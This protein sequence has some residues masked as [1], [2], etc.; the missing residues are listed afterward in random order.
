MKCLPVIKRSGHNM[1]FAII[2]GLVA[3]LAAV[4]LVIFLLYLVA[5]FQ[6]NRSWW[7]RGI[8]LLLP[9]MFSIGPQVTLLLRE[10]DWK[11]KLGAVLLYFTC[12][13]PTFYMC[14]IVVG[15]TGGLIAL[16]FDKFSR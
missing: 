3:Q 14:C 8:W 4:V 7:D 10:G 2:A 9:A 16:A 15:V 1:Q 13:I 6:N 11:Q 12:S 5:I